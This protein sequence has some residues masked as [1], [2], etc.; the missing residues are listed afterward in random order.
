MMGFKDDWAW[1]LAERRRKMR[2]R[3][4]HWMRQEEDKISC[5]EYPCERPQN[6]LGPISDSSHCCSGQ[7]PVQLCQLLPHA[8]RQHLAASPTWAPLSF[9]LVPPGE[10]PAVI[11]SALIQPV[12]VGN[13]LCT[14][15]PWVAGNMNLWINV[16]YSYPHGEKFWD[17]PYKMHRRSKRGWAPVIHNG[18]QLNITPLYSLPIFPVSLLVSFTPAPWNHIPK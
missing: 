7:C 2:M 17:A 11:C 3:V 13:L 1:N 6:L 10:S 9:A 15:T 8:S 14:G 4:N 18:G 16:S 12:S 5:T